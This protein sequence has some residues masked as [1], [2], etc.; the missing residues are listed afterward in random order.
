MVSLIA[1]TVLIISAGND[2]LLNNGFL[3]VS[4]YIF[5]VGMFIFV[6]LETYSITIN[7][8]H[9]I[10]K[11]KMLKKENQAIYEKSIRDG[12]TNLY[13]RHYIESILDNMIEIYNNEGV[14]FTIMMLDID[15]FKLVNDTYGHLCGDKVLLSV[16]NVLMKVIRST[17]YVGRYGGEEFIVI[18]AETRIEEAIEI[19]EGIRKN[20]EELSLDDG[21]KIT[22]SGG[23]YE[24]REDMKYTCIQ[25]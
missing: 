21:V 17:D 24:N 10:N 8:S 14:I 5:Q 9:Q 25:R 7:Y 2:M 16:S 20:I 1:F 3:H 13:N 22:I 12:L 6:L 11:V 15:F 19:A 4:R 23:L 18:F